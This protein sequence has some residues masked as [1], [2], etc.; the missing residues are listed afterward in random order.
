MGRTDVIFVDGYELSFCTTP[1]GIAVK[2]HEP[3]PKWSGE[4]CLVLQSAEPFTVTPQWLIKFMLVE[5]ITD[6]G[7]NATVTWVDDNGQ[8]R[9]FFLTENDERPSAQVLPFKPRAATESDEA[10]GT[11]VLEP[12]PN[13]DKTKH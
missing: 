13:T 6:F 2:A 1:D 5:L 4:P 9:E 7:I 10:G 11:P 12:Q 3:E 8:L